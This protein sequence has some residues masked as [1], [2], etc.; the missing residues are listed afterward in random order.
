MFKRFITIAGL[1]LALAQTAALHAVTRGQFFYAAATGDADTVQKAIDE[2]VEINFVNK[3]GETALDRA[4]GRTADVLRE[5]GG[6]KSSELGTDAGAQTR[7][8]QEAA[9]KQREEAERARR[10]QE[11]ARKEQ[12]KPEQAKQARR[13]RAPSE[14]P[15]QRQEREQKE[16]VRRRL[17]EFDR[18]LSD[19]GFVPDGSMK[20]QAMR[21]A[22]VASDPVWNEYINSMRESIRYA[23]GQPEQQQEQQLETSTAKFLTP[24][25]Q[26]ILGVRRG[27]SPHTVLGVDSRERVS[28]Q[29]RKAR[30]RLVEF[31]PDKWTDKKK[32]G[33]DDMTIE[34]KE[35]VTDIYQELSN[36]RDQ[37]DLK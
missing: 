15:A 25:M 11:Q 3:K 27:A 29:K 16:K 37:L 8:Q 7:A 2:G 31:H 12:Q 14:T 30:S 34:T 35:K 32:Y 6:L 10:A 36:I 20:L 21:V 5:A 4:K 17:A 9:R 28:V 26:K 33:P 22:K 18:L 24:R 23:K 1:V 19:A 13:E